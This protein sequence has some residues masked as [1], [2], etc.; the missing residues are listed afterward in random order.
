MEAR[1]R[2]G[3][4][5]PES[6]VPYNNIS[7]SV[8]DSP[9]HRKLSIIAAQQSMVLLKNANNLLPLKKNINAIA[10]IGPNADNPDVMYGNYNGIP[11]KYVTPLQGIKTQSPTIQKCIMHQVMVTWKDK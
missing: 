11:S 9:E 5:D 3:M 4:F 10:V 8:N 2:L 7:P 1:F 6:N